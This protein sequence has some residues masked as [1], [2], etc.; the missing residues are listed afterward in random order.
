MATTELEIYELDGEKIIT[1]SS[2]HGRMVASEVLGG[3]HAD[4]DAAD[5]TGLTCELNDDQKYHLKKHGWASVS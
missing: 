2:D 1:E 4:A 5:P 3:T